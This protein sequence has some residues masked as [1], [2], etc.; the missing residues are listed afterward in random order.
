MHY[1]QI[2]VRPEVT[3]PGVAPV[4]SLPKPMVRLSTRMRYAMEGTLASGTPIALTSSWSSENTVESF[5][6]PASTVI[7]FDPYPLPDLAERFPQGSEMRRYGYR[8]AW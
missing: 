6:T 8:K 5:P 2:A 1:E 7:N 3:K 4:L